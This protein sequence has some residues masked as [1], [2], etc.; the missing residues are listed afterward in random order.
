MVNDEDKVAGKVAS[1]EGNA[2][3]DHTVDSSRRPSE[4]DMR[5][6]FERPKRRAM[7]V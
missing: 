6:R 4:E 2:G 7:L 5:F 1:A 3:K